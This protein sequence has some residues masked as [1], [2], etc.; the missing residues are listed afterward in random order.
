MRALH[1][2]RFL[3]WAAV[4][5]ALSAACSSSDAGGQPGSG[6][7]EAGAGGDVCTTCSHDAGTHPPIDGSTCVPADESTYKPVEYKPASGAYQ[8]KCAAP[9]IPQFYDDCIAQTATAQSCAP[10]G[11]SGDAA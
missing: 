7:T 3:A 5:G 8:G 4:A 6:D 1:R 10:W 9:A 11:N 2:V